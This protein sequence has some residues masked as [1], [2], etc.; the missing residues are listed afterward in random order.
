MNRLVLLSC[1][2]LGVVASLGACG[3][4]PT[5]PEPGESFVLSVGDEALL[6]T[7]DTSVRF[8]SVSQDSRCPSRVQCVWA[9]DGAVV[10]EIAPMGVETA[11]DT[12][13]TNE[14]SGPRSV[15]LAGYELTL[16][17][18]DPY[19]EAPDGIPSGDYRATLVLTERPEGGTE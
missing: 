3:G 1:A 14:E 8:L 16:L 5:A 17:Q 2:A 4:E 10:L 11:E 12:L 15:A 18:L 6:D 9:G 19:P 7:I 13:H